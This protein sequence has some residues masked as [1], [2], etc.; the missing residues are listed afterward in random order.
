MN[1]GYEASDSHKWLLER[2]L[3]WKILTKGTPPPVL[4]QQFDPPDGLFPQNWPEPDEDISEAQRESH[5]VAALIM[6]DY[7]NRVPSTGVFPDV[8][9]QQT[10]NLEGRILEASVVYGLQ[11]DQIGSALNQAHGREVEIDVQ[12]NERFVRHSPAQLARQQQ[13]REIL[14][15]VSPTAADFHVADQLGIPTRTMHANI[16]PSQFPPVAEVSAPAFSGPPH[17]LVQEQQD[18]PTSTAL[19]SQSS[20]NAVSAQTKAEPKPKAAPKSLLRPEEP[21]SQYTS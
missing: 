3:D 20:E 12:A 18:A 21:F 10:L 8:P 2:D 6:D 15:N 7:D 19:S 9:F 17:K 4:R 14:L 13:A 1:A 5:I 16:D 11:P